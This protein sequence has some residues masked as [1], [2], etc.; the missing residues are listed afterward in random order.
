MAWRDRLN[1][2]ERKER[3]LYSGVLAYFPDALLE[4][5]YAS[6]I[7]NQQHNPGEPL[8]WAKEKSTDEPDA[9]A[10]H[11]LDRDRRDKDNVRHKAKVAWRAL[12]D[13]QRE[14]DDEETAIEMTQKPHPPEWVDPYYDHVSKEE[15]AAEAEKSVIP[16][17]PKPC[18]MGVGCNQ[19]GMCYAAAMG[20][21]GACPRG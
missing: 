12:A 8:H 13:L 3:P 14:L 20:H 19:T 18:T 17:P 15:I 21:P 5:A 6:F 1:A 16:E 10:R 2:Q 7:G 4:V 11:L 9:L